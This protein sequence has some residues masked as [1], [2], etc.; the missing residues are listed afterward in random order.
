M[1][2]P[3]R[4]TYS[5]EKQYMFEENIQQQK[6]AW[7]SSF[8]F[9]IWTLF[10]RN[11]LCDQSTWISIRAQPGKMALTVECFELNNNIIKV[12]IL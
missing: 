10:V 2:F 1:A 4:I 11:L 5:T 8:D 7:I 12:K 3:K 6:L 9:L